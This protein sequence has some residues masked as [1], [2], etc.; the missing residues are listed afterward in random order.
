M[1][2]ALRL[3]ILQIIHDPFYLT[4]SP[5]FLDSCSHSFNTA[6]LVLRLYNFP[7]FYLLPTVIL[8]ERTNTRHPN[9][10]LHLL[11]QTHILT[12][13]RLPPLLLTLRT[14][15]FP[16]NGPPGPARPVP[17]AEEQL[18]IR[19]NAAKAILSLTPRWSDGIWV[20]S[21][22]GGLFAR[23]GRAKKEEDT[24]KKPK[25]PNEDV[26]KEV[27]GL[28]DVFGDSYMNR[29]LV[30]GI[31]E[32]VLVRLCPEVGQKTTSQLIDERLGSRVEETDGMHL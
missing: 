21:A 6:P 14:T 9:R 10:F 16:N 25:E 32:L 17:S 29:H 1:S 27:E 5:L 26:I 15:L 24:G 28:L 8:P 19:R 30:F 2:L 7:S 18:V 20:G 3:F 12:P 22:N 31:I 23:E 11:I 13:S 4:F